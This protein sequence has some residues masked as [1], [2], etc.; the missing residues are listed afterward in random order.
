MVPSWGVQ[1]TVLSHYLATLIATLSYIYRTYRKIMCRN[2]I[3]ITPK[4]ISMDTQN[5]GL[6]NVSPFKSSYFGMWNFGGLVW[7]IFPRPQPTS[8]QLMST[9]WW[10]TS[11]IE[12]KIFV[13][14]KWDAK[15]M[16]WRYF[17]PLILRK[18]WEHPKIT[19][20]KLVLITSI[21]L[22][23]FWYCWWFRNPAITS[24]CSS[25]SHYL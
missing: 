9:S 10:A 21:N 4:K 8:P 19:H 20:P 17:F 12:T 2:K 22:D 3:S 13:L 24:S 25:F 15:R 11:G 7:T 5:D 6:E 1:Q 18:K 14:S 23:H 16:A